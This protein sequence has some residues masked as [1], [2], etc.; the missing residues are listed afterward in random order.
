MPTYEYECRRTGRRFEV[1]QSMREKPV[2]K[3]PECGGP[4]HRVIS[5]GV[6]VIV[7]GAGSGGGPAQAPS[8][9]RDRPCC[10]RDTRCDSPGCGQGS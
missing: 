10:G 5:A 6:G 7:K 4:A 2:G 9:G 8:C 3:C 1:F